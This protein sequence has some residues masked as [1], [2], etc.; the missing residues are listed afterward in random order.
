M[1]R[2][3]ERWIELGLYDPVDEGRVR[4]IVVPLPSTSRTLALFR[5]VMQNRLEI[6]GDLR[7]KALSCFEVNASRFGQ[8]ALES[9]EPAYS[10]GYCRGYS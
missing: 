8:H 5:A 4:L 9:V 2:L 10:R 7:A 3:R 6:R 1:T